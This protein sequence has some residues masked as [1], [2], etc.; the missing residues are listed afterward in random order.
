M[1]TYGRS[2]RP[3]VRDAWNL[4]HPRRISWHG[5]TNSCFVCIRGMLA[6][7]M[8][9]AGRC[10]SCWRQQTLTASCVLEF[11]ARRVLA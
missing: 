4:L 1:P 3:V 11:S 9:N 6:C 2:N 8:Q 7:R 10:S 5:A